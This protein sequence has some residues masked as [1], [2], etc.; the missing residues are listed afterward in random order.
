M[1][2]TEEEGESC[3][4][5]CDNL[6]AIYES[7]YGKAPVRMTACDEVIGLPGDVFVGGEDGG[8]R[9]AQ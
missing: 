8:G 1:R 9:V 4:A 5:G 7:M 3:V 6:A 2:E